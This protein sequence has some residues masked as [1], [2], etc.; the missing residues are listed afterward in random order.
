M[1]AGQYIVVVV[2]FEM[3]SSPLGLDGPDIHMQG[4][5]CL[6]DD[7]GRGRFDQRKERYLRRTCWDLFLRMLLANNLHFGLKD[8]SHH[9][10]RLRRSESKGP[11]NE[12][13]V[14][15]ADRIMWKCEGL[16]LTSLRCITTTYH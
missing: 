5:G 9:G 15:K 4:S 13:L 14:F 10:I 7:T 2:D 12:Q 11:N 3:N 16:I 6:V 1:D 8:L